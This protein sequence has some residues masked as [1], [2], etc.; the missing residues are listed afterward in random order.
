MLD[1]A[2]IICR[3]SFTLLVASIPFNPVSYHTGLFFMQKK[4]FKKCK[5][6]L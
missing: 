2:N 3:N 6:E 4:Y 1:R 5:K